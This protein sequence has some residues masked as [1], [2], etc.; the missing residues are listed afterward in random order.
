M[1]FRAGT[2]FR[3]RRFGAG[4]ADPF[5]SP[6]RNIKITLGEI[7]NGCMIAVETRNMI[8]GG[9]DDPRTA[10][11]TGPAESARKNRRRQTINQTKPL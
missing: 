4:A 1:I 2:V 7:E 10:A 5:F 8:P 6:K 3:S 9:W 11:E